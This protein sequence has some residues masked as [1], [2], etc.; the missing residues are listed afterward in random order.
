MVGGHGPPQSKL[1]SP[2][3]C[4]PSEQ[5]ALWQLPPSQTPS[6]VVGILVAAA[7]AAW[8]LVELLL[9]ALFLGVYYFT[10]KAVGRVARDRHDC[11]GNLARSVGWGSL[12]AA[13]YVFPVGLLVWGVHF[14][15]QL[16]AGLP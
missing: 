13:L 12:W 7:F 16:K 14:L 6:V 4:T 10:L 1:S 2:A 15:L 5:V 9:P 8:V 3:F 11:Q